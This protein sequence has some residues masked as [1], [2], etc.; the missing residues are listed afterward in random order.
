M[1]MVLRTVTHPNQAK[2][3]ATDSERC[4]IK[5]KTGTGTAD[6]VGANSSSTSTIKRRVPMSR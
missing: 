4:A 3:E 5:T 2:A 6:E 1:S